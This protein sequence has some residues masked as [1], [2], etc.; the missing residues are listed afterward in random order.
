MGSSSARRFLFV[1]IVLSS[2]C[3][4]VDYERSGLM[5]A[6]DAGSTHDEGAGT[7]PA[8]TLLIATPTEASFCVERND[9]VAA[10]FEAAR[11]ACLAEGRHLCTDDEWRL[12]C[13]LG[14]AMFLDLSDDWEWVDL[15]VDA[16]TAKKR[17][18][19]CGDTSSHAVADPYPYR[20]CAPLSL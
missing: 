17:G 4:R 14:G 15:L 11:S 2:A 10:P 6:M 9:R 16:A 7:C 20:C 12:G 8:D 5:G 1:S 18:Y 13:E 19:T 3:G